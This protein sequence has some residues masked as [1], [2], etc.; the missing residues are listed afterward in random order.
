MKFF[1][2]F[3]PKKTA[4]EIQIKKDLKLV[5]PESAKYDINKIEFNSKTELIDVLNF[6]KDNKVFSGIELNKPATENDIDFFER[7]KKI[8]LPN[9]FKTLYKFSDGFETD[10][11]LFRLIPLS[12]ITD[13]GKDNYC[14]NDTSFHFTEHMI[15]SDMWTVEISPNDFENYKIYSKK[16]DIVYLTN[17]LAEFLC[18]FINKRIY[19][20]LYEWREKK[21]TTIDKVRN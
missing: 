1:N 18:V 2:F 9:D 20:G 17:S 8:K 6:I 13:N 11:D 5:R 10:E 7:R 19:E 4:E 21:Q 16:D 3:K 15:Y 12:E 14:I